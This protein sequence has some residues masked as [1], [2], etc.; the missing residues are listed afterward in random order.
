MAISEGGVQH[1]DYISIT[2]DQNLALDAMLLTDYSLC[3]LDNKQ[4]QVVLSNTIDQRVDFTQTPI[5]IVLEIRGDMVK[6]TVIALHTDGMEGLE[7]DTIMILPDFTLGLGDYTIKTYISTPSSDY[8]RLDDT[9]SRTMAINPEFQV[10][11][12]TLSNDE[13]DLAFAEY[14]YKQIV[15]VTNTGNL[16]LSDIT[17]LFSVDVDGSEYFAAE[18]TT[19]TTIAVGDS[20]VIAFNEA[21]TVP[22][23]LDYDVEVYGYLQCDSANVYHHAYEQERVDINDLYLV[24][25]LTPSGNVLDTAGKQ[26]E[27]SIEVR[28]RNL[29]GVYGEG[30][31]NVYLLITDTNGVEQQR[32]EEV[33]PR[34]EGITPVYYTFVDKYTVPALEKYHLT[35]FVESNDEYTY[36][37]TITIIRE[38]TSDVSLVEKSKVSFT[39]GQNIPNPAE[40]NTIINYNIP[41]DG[42]I[43]FHVYGANG[44]LLYSRKETVYS[45]DHQIELNISDYASGIYFYMMEY[46]GQRIVKRMSVK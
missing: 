38:V 27:V 16:D 21:Y 45:G 23:I 34:I 44:Q 19:G 29:G 4:L 8:Y 33:L 31:V 25:I 39:M 24:D 28:G 2:S 11:I 18:T 22:W 41:Q 3:N 14:E 12:H 20:I 7:T 43:T 37:D 35:V 9:I 17:L 13:G 5:D 46:K 6:D 10:R 42:E 32:I 40:G 1:I 30:T 26:Q 15:T 36:D